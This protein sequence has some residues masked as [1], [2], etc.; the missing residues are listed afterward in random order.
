MRP[1]TTDEE[2]AR[3]C[4]LTDEFLS[5]VGPRLQRY[6]MLK[7]WLST[8]YVSDLRVLRKFVHSYI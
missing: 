5:G 4:T 1:I 2:Y 7:S 3:L 8:N 6:L